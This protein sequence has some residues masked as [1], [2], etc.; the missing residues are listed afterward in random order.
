MCN[1]RFKRWFAARPRGQALAWIALGALAGCTASPSVNIFGSYFPSWMLCAFA[2]LLLTALTSVAFGAAGIDKV[3]PEVCVEPQ[4]VKSTM[5]DIRRALG[6]SPKKP[7]FTET[8][9]KRG[10]SFIAPVANGALDTRVG[11]DSAP[12]T[13]V[14]SA[15]GS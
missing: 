8:L 15:A 6:D 3:W 9:P 13:L 1:D 2:G 10:Y 11:D 14:C 12:S 5:F 7:V 4:A